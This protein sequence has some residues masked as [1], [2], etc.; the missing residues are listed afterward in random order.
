MQYEYQNKRILGKLRRAVDDYHMIE[1]GD[2][3][4]VGLSGGKDSVALLV[5]LCDLRRFYPISFTL[6]AFHIDMSFYEAGFGKAQDAQ[7]SIAELNN[8]CRELAVPFTVEKT[9]IAKIVFEA[10][11][12]QNPCSLCSKMRRGALHDLIIRHGCNKLALGHHFDDAVETFLMNL[13]NEGRLG[14]FSPVT[15]LEQKQISLIRPFLYVPEKDIKYFIA[16]SNLPVYKSVCPA[17]KHSDRQRI[18]ELL[19]VQ[20]K[21]HKGLKHRIFGAMQRA[22]IDGFY[23][24]GGNRDHGKECDHVKDKTKESGL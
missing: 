6:H 3:I 21:E 19:A 7:G 17:D 8:L 15:Y 18:K 23:L 1:E 5:S 24:P 11:Q 20:N 22:G 9:Q 14:C 4:A 10:R 16:H 12:E 2:K 13:F